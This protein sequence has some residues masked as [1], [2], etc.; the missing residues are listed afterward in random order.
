MKSL[1]VVVGCGIAGD[2]AAF[3]A[4]SA[5]PEARIIIFTQEP[6][7]LYSACVLADYVAGEIPKSRVLLR[8]PEDYESAGIELLLS[9]KVMDLSPD[10]RI[11]HLED[12]ELSYD[13]LVLAT[14]SHSFIPPLPG[15]DKKG[16][17]TL[18]NLSD[19]DLLREVTGRSAAVIGSGP[20]GI[21]AAVALR[22]RG[23][24]V[25]LFELLDR[26]L[27]GLFDPPIAK[28]LQ[29][30][31]V[32]EGIEVHTGERL[33]EIL[34]DGRVKAIRTDKGRVPCDLV[35]LVIGM[36]PDVS[37]TK[38]GGIELGASGG[39]QVDDAMATSREGVWA[40]GDCIESRDRI[41]G[42]RGLNMLWHNAR[43]QGNIAG[44][45]AGGERRLYSGSMNITTV[46][47]FDSGAATVG[48]L[49]S[50]IPEDEAKVIHRKG[51]WGE[52]RLV[53]QGER[54]VGVQALGRIERV[55][56]LLGILLRGGQIRETLERGHI[57]QGRE[58]WALRG[59]QRELREILNEP[60]MEGNED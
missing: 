41:T 34:G 19:A 53:L 51:P 39:I 27:P 43:W 17:F 13:K 57:H 22:R 8:R 12:G 49:A 37:L 56:G 47:I 9:K 26:V 11:L 44:A 35:V 2:Q 58:L 20:V 31:L 5:D 54:L 32:K 3:S 25:V 4:K 40:C 42:R 50:D 1:I 23:F 48:A 15:L 38:K 30:L 33:L 45:N 28:S 29:T 6:Q 21:E 24:A 7:P 14:G 55:G 18:K 59:V 36:R 52:F 60:L 10:R 46:N 16:V